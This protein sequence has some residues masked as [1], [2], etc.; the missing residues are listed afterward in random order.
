MFLEISAPMKKRMEE[1]EVLD[2]KD[3]ENGTERMARLRQIPP[4]TG[5]FLALIAANCPVGQYLEIGTSAG[6]SAMWISLAIRLRGI[7]LR[8]Y[9]I[10]PEK[11]KLARETFRLAQ[12][13]D[14][15]E[16]IEKDFLY[17]ASGLHKIAFCFIDAEKEIY[18]QCFE[19]VTDKMIPGSFLVAD[20]AI[21]HY[22]TLAPVIER[23]SNDN[24]FD[25]VVVPIGKGE[26]VCRRK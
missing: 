14:S 24:R 13:E 17:N 5:K 22:Q 18:G 9:E 11:A 4:E 1:L 25:S 23:I 16:L 7:R 20:N 3:R 19:L 8:T 6:Y 2:R 21:S 10:L 12:I 26:L 15:V